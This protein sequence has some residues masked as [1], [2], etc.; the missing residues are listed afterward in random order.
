MLEAIQLHRMLEAIQLHRMLVVKPLI[1]SRF[2]CR[3]LLITAWAAES[4]L[5]N[6][7]F[8][9]SHLSVMFAVSHL[10]VMFAVIHLSVT[11]LV[12]LFSDII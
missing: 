4:N 6:C 8:A 1:C 10:S 2:K 3:K 11:I 7:T 5:K 12:L 9:V